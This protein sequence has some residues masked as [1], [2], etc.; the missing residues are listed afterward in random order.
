VASPNSWQ[1]VMANRALNQSYSEG[2]FRGAGA[3]LC[4]LRDLRIRIH[5]VDFSLDQWN[6]SLHFDKWL[7][8]FFA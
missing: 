2:A 1:F 6:H 7:N 8:R 4:Y 3:Q 5:A